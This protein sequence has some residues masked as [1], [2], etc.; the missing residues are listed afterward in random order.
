MRVDTQ[1]KTALVIL[2]SDSLRDWIFQ[3]LIMHNCD[4][5][6]FKWIKFSLVFNLTSEPVCFHNQMITCKLSVFPLENSFRGREAAVSIL[7]MRAF[8]SVFVCLLYNLQNKTGQL[9]KLLK[10]SLKKLPIPLLNF[11]S[12]HHSSQNIDNMFWI[13]EL[14]I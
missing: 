9:T 1:L 3:L 4:P 7:A 10:T 14:W 5:R 12:C 8:F 2:S 11:R 6:L 13:C